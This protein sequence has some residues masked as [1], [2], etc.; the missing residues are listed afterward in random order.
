MFRQH[1]FSMDLN[2]VVQQNKQGERTER[3]KLI[4]KMDL[5]SDAMFRSNR[6]SHSDDYKLTKQEYEEIML[7]GAYK[8]INTTEQVVCEDEERNG[9]IVSFNILYIDFTKGGR[10]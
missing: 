2:H 5:D 9:E 10:K 1:E 7:Q 4:D 3:E 8:V 6:H